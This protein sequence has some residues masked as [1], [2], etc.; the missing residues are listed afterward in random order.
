M[1]WRGKI[2]VSFENYMECSNSRIVSVVKYTVLCVLITKIMYHRGEVERLMFKPGGRCTNHH[3]LKCKLFSLE[4]H[5]EVMQS[6]QAWRSDI[7]V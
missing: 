7:Y 4:E 2:L 5:K 6:Q 3:A 1:L